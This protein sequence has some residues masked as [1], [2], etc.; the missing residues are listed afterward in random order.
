MFLQ[1]WRLFGKDCY[2]P[3]PVRTFHTLGFFGWLLKASC[4]LPFQYAARR[5]PL[6]SSSE[7]VLAAIS[8]DVATPW[9]SSSKAL[10]HF[11]PPPAGN[12]L[13]FSVPGCSLPSRTV[14]W[15]A[16]APSGPPQASSAHKP[17]LPPPP[18]RRLPR[19]CRGP[20]G[21]RGPAAADGRDR[22]KPGVLPAPSHGRIKA[23]IRGETAQ[24]APTANF[25]RLLGD[26]EPAPG[27]LPR[28]G[29]RGRGR[30]AAGARRERGGPRPPLRLPLVPARLRAGGEAPAEPVRLPRGASSQPAAVLPGCGSAGG[31]RAP[32]GLGR[33][34]GWV[35]P[36]PSAAGKK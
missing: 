3:S 19:S 31:G 24:P 9:L 6:S 25:P 15:A 18:P 13:P 7:P 14:R 17:V 27:P 8:R 1:V 10:P 26:P 4:M 5:L 32:P 20:A 30:A 12:L 16:P 2:S 23:L 33:G 35:R 29:G 22:S 36:L 11:T 21:T 34:R 28:L